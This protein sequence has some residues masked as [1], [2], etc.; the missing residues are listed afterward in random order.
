MG[1]NTYDSYD[2]IQNAVK[3]I[4]ETVTTRG[5]K[6]FLTLQQMIDT[7]L[8]APMA[9]KWEISTLYDAILSLCIFASI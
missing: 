6:I 7:I 9:M 3:C 1:E 2:C 8:K 5:F 4:R